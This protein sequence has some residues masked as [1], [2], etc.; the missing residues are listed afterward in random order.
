MLN[1][2]MS[3][4][5]YCIALCVLL[6]VALA[7]KLAEWRTMN[8]LL[9]AAKSVKET[10]SHNLIKQMKLGYTNAYKLNYDVNN[11][12]AFIEKYLGR[13]KVGKFSMSF[14]G[15][16][17]EKIML[18]CGI[19]CLISIMSAFYS[20][21]TTENVVIASGLGVLSVFIVRLFS[22]VF[23]VEQKRQQFVVL[24]VD[25]FENV[26][27][28]RLSNHK[29]D[30]K[31]IISAEDRFPK[32]PKPKEAKAVFGESEKA[33]KAAF[34]ESEPDSQTAAAKTSEEA[35]VEEIIREFFP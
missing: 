23:S 19:I 25:Y 32:N 2:I 21:V 22:V 3:Q 8:K 7:G 17:D 14:I 35:I 4:K 28:N 20:G 10:E 1:I 6:T 15:T 13:C 11:T 34:G 18:L 33:A 29:K 26:L 5:E 30:N 12:N 16:L 9:H 31:K 24:M 27:K